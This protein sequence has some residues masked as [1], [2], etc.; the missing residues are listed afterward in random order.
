M[1]FI[2]VTLLQDPLFMKKLVI[3]SYIER[4]YT[5]FNVVT[6]FTSN[7][8]VIWNM[9]PAP[10]TDKVVLQ[11]KLDCLDDV[12]GSGQLAV[13]LDFVTKNFTRLF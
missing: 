10:I 4:Y 12:L 5:K 7:Q 11:E 1:S 6:A 2:P 3:T 9:S 8:D 13:T